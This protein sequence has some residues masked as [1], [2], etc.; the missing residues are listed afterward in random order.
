MLLV[1]FK[2]ARCSGMKKYNVSAIVW[3]LLAGFIVALSAGAQAPPNGTTVYRCIDLNGVVSFADAPCTKSVSH[4]LRIEHSLIQSV[5]ISIEE[6]QRL[7]ALEA[8]LNS[9]R[10]DKKSRKS[11]SKK[12]RLAQAAASALRCKQARLGLTQ[13]RLRKKRGYPIGQSERIDNE[14]EALQGEIKTHCNDRP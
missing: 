6:Q 5:P 8:R 2:R 3:L 7:Y 4:R 11:A 14:H 10:S 13:I 12:Q 9:Q 1:H